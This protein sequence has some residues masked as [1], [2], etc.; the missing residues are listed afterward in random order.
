MELMLIHGLGQDSSSWNEVRSLLSESIHVQC[1]NLHELPNGEE[2]TY[3]NLYTAFSDYCKTF[4]QPLNL[5]GLSLG[6]ILALN[7]TIDNPEKVQSL[8][9][10]GAQYRIANKALFKL[11]SI[12]FKIMPKSFFQNM[13]FQKKDVISLSNSITD[14]DFSSKLKSIS[15]ETLILCG[16][17]D[18]PINIKASEDLA[19]SIANAKLK[20]IENAAHEVNKNNPQKLSFEINEFYR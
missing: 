17:K 7:Y 9:L 13:G 2:I 3:T 12:I 16:K 4:S 19:E 8:V 20:L 10:I 6:G 18:N 1:P 5:C 15:C 11:Q 14:I